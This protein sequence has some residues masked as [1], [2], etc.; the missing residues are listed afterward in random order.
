[1]ANIFRSWLWTVIELRY[2]FGNDHLIYND[3]NS[4]PAVIGGVGVG[5]WSDV[6]RDG[7]HVSFKATVETNP[8]P[9]ASWLSPRYHEKKELPEASRS[10][11]RLTG[12][13]SFAVLRLPRGTYVSSGVVGTHSGSLFPARFPGSVFSRFLSY[14]QYDTEGV[15]H[16]SLVVKEEMRAQLSEQNGA[17]STWSTNFKHVS[18]FIPSLRGV[19]GVNHGRTSSTAQASQN[20]LPP[21]RI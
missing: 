11:V 7:L 3:S 16:R 1:M 12:T 21:R 13:M 6:Q 15:T 17:W 9:V 5:F 10:A 14:H 4:A 18:C 8:A 2:L 19:Q 20:A